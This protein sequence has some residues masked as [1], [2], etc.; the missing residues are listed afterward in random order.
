MTL[1]H[2]SDLRPC[3]ASF[4]VEGKSIGLVP[5]MGFLHEGHL[6]LIRKAK[7]ENDIV[8]VS[9]F[10]NPTQFA[11]HEDLEKYP[12]DIAGDSARASAAG[13]DL[14]FV[15]PVGEMYPPGFSSYAA[16][17]GLSS[18]LEG[19]FR[20]THFKGVTTV[21]LKLFNIVRP[22][23]SY[24][25][26]K[27]A[28]QCIVIKKMVSDLNVPLQVMIVPTMRE[29]DGLAMSSRNVYLDPEQRKNAVV[30]SK[31]LTLASEMIV[32]GERDPMRI[33]EMMRTCIA[34]GGPTSIDYIAVVDAQDLS[35][36]SMLVSGETILIPLAVRFGATRLID[37][38]LI[39]V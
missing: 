20:P 1:T 5:T 10:V 32:R 24:F 34:S 11:P 9:I 37:N 23:R 15:P 26:Q 19:E 31:S 28:Q 35:S 14:L 4:R 39:T 17:E 2:I 29:P 33:I 13:C 38:A 27:D 18:V 21:V 6:S 30:L 12:R 25:G 16:V 8:V 36:K 7:N 3:L 22:D